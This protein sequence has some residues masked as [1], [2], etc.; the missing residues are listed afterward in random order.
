[1]AAK[2]PP[3]SNAAS[4]MPSGCLG[5]AS[6]VALCG[7]EIFRD[8]V[9]KN[10][11]LLGVFLMAIRA[12]GLCVAV[13]GKGV[14]VDLMLRHAKRERKNIKQDHGGWTPTR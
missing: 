1:M 2:R 9:K 14:F 6:M 11:V 3:G 7:V 4:P 10:F 13:S 5:A 8:V 12:F